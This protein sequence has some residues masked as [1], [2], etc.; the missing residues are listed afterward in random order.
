MLQSI[1]GFYDRFAALNETNA[2]L[3]REAAKAHRRIGEL[4]QRLGQFDAAD[5]AFGRSAA[6]FEALALEFP[7]SPDDR[8]ALAETLV[9]HEP[10]SDAPDAL[11][12]TLESLA[13][14]PG[15]SRRSSP[16]DLPG[17]ME[18]VAA[19]AGIESKLGSVLDRLGRT[20]E[21]EA[22]LQRA[23]DLRHSLA[24]RFPDGSYPKLLR[25]VART[26]LGGFLIKHQQPAEARVCL[27]TCVAEVRAMASRSLPYSVLRV[28]AVEFDDLAALYKSLGD[29]T[30]AEELAALARNV[31]EPR[32][33]GR[34]TAVLPA[35]AAAP[36]PGNST[37]PHRLHPVCPGNPVP[38]GLPPGARG[39]FPDG[40]DR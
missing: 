1:L 28:L 38:A 19:L 32:Q 26:A 25:A 23:V 16:R 11:E 20:D 37:V 36:V 22:S 21:A 14:M 3:K 8:H 29:P 5:V 13:A 10:R 35:E 7:D 6:L 15:R 2:T 33:S 9:V 30:R 12:S 39:P 34:R 18:Y 24:E 40:P 17:Q 4:R 27:D 31:H